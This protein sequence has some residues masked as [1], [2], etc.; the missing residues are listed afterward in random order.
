[1]NQK[2]HAACAFAILPPVLLGANPSERDGI[3]EL[4]MTRV[5]AERE[6][7]LAPRARAVIVAVA[8]MIFDVAAAVG[9]GD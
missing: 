6:M 2:R 5:K 8:Q 1:M 9:V 4:Q 3:D 7:H